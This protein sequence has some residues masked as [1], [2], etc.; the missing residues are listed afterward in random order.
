MVRIVETWKWRDTKK[1]INYTC[2]KTD[3]GKQYM[4]YTDGMRTLIKEIEPTH[5]AY[6]HS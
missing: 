2:F 1:R 6:R 5:K 3:D 4:I